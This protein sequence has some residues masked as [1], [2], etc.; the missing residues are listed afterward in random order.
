M[1]TVARAIARAGVHAAAIPAAPFYAL[2]PGD[3]LG[4]QAPDDAMPDR[5]V[6]VDSGMRWVDFG[7]GPRS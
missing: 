7:G 3:M 4:E 6:T 2:T 1:V 5:V